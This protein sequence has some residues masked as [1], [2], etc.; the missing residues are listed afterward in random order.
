MS[1]TRTPIRLPSY[2]PTYSTPTHIPS[3][4]LTRDPATP[5]LFVPWMEQLVLR[6]TSH[7]WCGGL[8]N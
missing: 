2:S 1:L 3:R 7:C 4:P 8:A 6:N 5:P